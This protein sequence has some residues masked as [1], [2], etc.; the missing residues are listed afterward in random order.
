MWITLTWQ[1]IS[2]LFI[3]TSNQRCTSRCSSLYPLHITPPCLFSFPSGKSP[4]SMEN[5]HGFNGKST[6]STNFLWPFSIANFFRV[7]Q[8][9]TSLYH[10]TS[11]SLYPHYTITTPACWGE[12][13]QVAPLPTLHSLSGPVPPATPPAAGSWARR[14]D[15]SMLDMWLI[16]LWYPHWQTHVSTGLSGQ[17][18]VSVWAERGGNYLLWIAKTTAWGN[19]WSPG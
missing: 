5:P 17:L 6:K 12:T 1:Q 4:C 9:V 8:M 18:S 19:E 7:Y 16:P 3:L 2:V 15:A 14:I 11:L 13:N 10:S